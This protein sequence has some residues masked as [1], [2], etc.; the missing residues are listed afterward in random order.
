MIRFGRIFDQATGVER[1]KIREVQA[2]FRQVFTGVSGYADRI[3]ELVASRGALPFDVV[4]LT[5]ED[6]RDRVLGFALVHVYP[7]IH[8][9]YLDYIATDPAA[10]RRGLGGALYEALR[11]HLGGKGVRGLF[12][13]VPPDDPAMVRDPARLPANQ[14]RLRFYERYGAFPITGTLYDGPPPAGK[15]Y[16]PPFLVYDPLGR[17]T[18]LSQADARKAIRA[19]LT[20]KYGYDGDDPYVA[21]VAASFRDDPV[22]LREPRYAIP[23]PSPSHAHGRLWPIKM[24]VSEAHEIHHVRERGYVERPVRVG[25]ILRA[26]AD[27]PIERRPVRHHDERPIRAVHDGDFVSYL[28]ACC[29]TLRPEDTVY[30]YVFPIRRAERKPRE[31]A[32]R[33]GYYCIDT[34]TPLT[35]NAYAAARAAVDCAV[36]GADLVLRGEQL[37]YALCRPP[38]HHAERRTFGGFCYFNNAAIAAH[39]LTE[40]GRVALLD[41]DYHHGNGSQEIFYRRED[42]FFL[43]IHGHPKNAYPYFSGFADER[44]E[45]AGVGRNRNF[46]LPD[47][48]DDVHY[49]EV[50]AAALADIR[51]FRPAALV[52]SLG[53]DIM[54]GDPTGGFVVSPRGMRRIGEAI[55]RVGVPTLVVQE[56]GYS[57][58]NLGRGARAFFLGLAR[59]WY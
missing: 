41:I 22:K 7:T 23:R 38:G 54:R 6:E 48:V 24:V 14:K 53:F 12:M 57:I 45:A 42:V 18:P 52:V 59:A 16:D 28:A 56:G 32:L 15:D 39:R 33:A 4:L 1:R 21:K 43:S 46:P 35:R 37:V 55:G 3:P 27:L 19:I 49:L 44:G 8:Y 26:I 50:L 2:I 5:A 51:A 9:A 34:F 25:A 47:G 31:R 13:D 10:R 29:R 11:E 20:L 40:L 58:A 17:A 36:S 30:P